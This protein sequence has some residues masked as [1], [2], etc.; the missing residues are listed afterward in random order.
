MLIII[1]ILITIIYKYDIIKKDL[2]NENITND[3]FIKYS[4]INNR[5]ITHEDY[6]NLYIYLET[7]KSSI[8]YNI[9]DTI[10]INENK[11]IEL[12]SNDI[13]AT[14]LKYNLKNLKN[15]YVLIKQK[16][17]YNKI[18]IFYDGLIY[19]TQKINFKEN[20][21]TGNTIIY[22]LDLNNKLIKYHFE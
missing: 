14:K 6:I 15:I 5:L 18:I 20:D 8:Y 2:N 3:I 13:I 7:I 9:I 12:I 21:F 22:K 10:I 19:N 4:S 11:I 16:D 17:N 1:L